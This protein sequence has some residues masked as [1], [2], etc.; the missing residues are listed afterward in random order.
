MQEATY[1]FGSVY[2]YIVNDIKTV[3][4]NHKNTKLNTV[5]LARQTPQ[6]DTIYLYCQ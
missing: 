4:Q 6:E 1:N 2:T 3:N 5:S